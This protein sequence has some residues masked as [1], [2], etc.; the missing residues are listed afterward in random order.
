MSKTSNTNRIRAFA[1]YLE[2]VRPSLP[3]FYRITAEEQLWSLQYVAGRE[4]EPLP[5]EE[6]DMKAETI[7]YLRE[8]RDQMAQHRARFM[9][10]D[11]EAGAYLFAKACWCL[12]HWCTAT[13][14][15]T[16]VTRQAS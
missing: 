9:V 16:E 8:L 15:E 12:K 2:Q 1:Q 13:H 7:A 10:S 6:L 11:V 4:Q 14:D 3:R 5:T